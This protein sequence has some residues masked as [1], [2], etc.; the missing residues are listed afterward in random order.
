MAILTVPRDD[1]LDILLSAYDLGPRKAAR[2][3]EAG[4]VNTS[5][6]LDLGAGRYFLRLYEE[7]DGAGA[8]AE[9]LLLQHLAASGVRTP[10][11]VVARDG[12]MVRLVAGKPAALF[13]W[14]AG[15]MLCLRA[16][17][18]AAARAVGAALARMHLAGPAPAA[19]LGAGRF[20]PAE[21]VQRCD[22]V[23]ASDNAEAKLLAGALRVRLLAAAAA[24]TESST[25]AHGGSE[26][27]L[28]PS[29]RI[30]G[31]GPTWMWASLRPGTTRRPSRS[32]TVVS[33]PARH[34][35]GVGRNPDEHREGSGAALAPPRRPVS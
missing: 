25:V 14:V 18:P 12:T 10:A 20:G 24:R 28:I 32:S 17:T 11:P 5:Y 35:G 9:A 30:A 27:P 22:R 4:T 34:P 7:Q 23:A 1:E 31:H 3:I 15:D 16:V 26:G 8:A 19:P 29:S 6:A 13:P 33:G 2:G 21:L